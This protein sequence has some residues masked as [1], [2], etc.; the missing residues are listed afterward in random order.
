MTEFVPAFE[1]AWAIRGESDLPLQ[2]HARRKAVLRRQKLVHTA[3]AIGWRFLRFGEPV[4]RDLSLVVGI[5]LDRREDF[6]FLDLLRVHAD[7]WR[8]R[9]VQVFQADKPH[10]LPFPAPFTQTPV[11]AA[12]EGNELR[13]FVEGASA[14]EF[15]LGRRPGCS[16]GP[17]GP[18]RV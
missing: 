14:Y 11:L 16:P 12:F 1:S 3:R 4:S 2:E 9:D 7:L 18:G 13:A 17:E 6:A 8:G 5:S 15:V 10:L